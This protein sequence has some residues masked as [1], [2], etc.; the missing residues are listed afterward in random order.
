MDELLDLENQGWKALCDGTAGDFYG[1]V[2][3]KNAVMIMGNGQ[4]MTRDDVVKA[5]ADSP[6]WDSYAIDD[7]QVFEL[8]DDTHAVVYTGTGHRS[9]GDPFVG[10]M[11]TVYVRSGKNWQLALHQQTPTPKK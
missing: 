6:A 8:A 11:T 7:A 3:A 2:M 10:T 9:E 1:R 5:L 4:V